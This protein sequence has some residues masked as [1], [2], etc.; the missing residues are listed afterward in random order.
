[1]NK[2]IKDKWVAALESG[3]YEQG[4]GKLKRDNK[5]C[6]LGVLTDI[7]I[8]ENNLEWEENENDYCLLD[9]FSETLSISVREWAE[10]NKESKQ[11]ILPEL[12]N[13]NDSQSK[14]FKQIAKVIKETL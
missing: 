3:E 8:K 4:K 10:M 6:C 11:T 7:Y 2:E 1:M 5:F 9:G 13:L 12:I 14:T